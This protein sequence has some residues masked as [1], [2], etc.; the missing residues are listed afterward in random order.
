ML[1]D[2]NKGRPIRERLTDL[3]SQEVHNRVERNSGKDN[4]SHAYNPNPG[5]VIGR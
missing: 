1:R 4:E 5:E 2:V 3:S